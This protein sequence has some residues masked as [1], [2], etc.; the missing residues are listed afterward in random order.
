MARLERTCAS[1]RRLPI[2]RYS[3]RASSWWTREAS[4]SP[5][6]S[7]TL[8][9]FCRDRCLAHAVSGATVQRERRL[10]AGPDI[11]QRA[12]LAK[13]LGDLVAGVFSGGR[14]LADHLE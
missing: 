6:W 7:N 1:P 9:R 3:A 14:A 13:D 8:P 2:A 10:G 5:S 11:R 4:G 12:L